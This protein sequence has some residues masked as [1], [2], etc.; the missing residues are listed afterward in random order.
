[1][2]CPPG[3]CANQG[4]LAAEA[5]A[6]E[7]PAGGA[8]WAVGDAVLCEVRCVWA[9]LALTVSN[10]SVFSVKLYVPEPDK[11]ERIVRDC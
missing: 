10:H 7:G 8:R 4:G 5:R 2:F 1:M 9:H 3:Q 6:A 11:S